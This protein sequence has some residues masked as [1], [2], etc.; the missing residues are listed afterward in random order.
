MILK[1]LSQYNYPLSLNLDY[2]FLKVTIN[3]WHLI[4]NPICFFK[5]WAL[6]IS[7]NANYVA[8]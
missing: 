5:G 8:K 4:Q 3:W 7:S 1:Y 2:F 6:F